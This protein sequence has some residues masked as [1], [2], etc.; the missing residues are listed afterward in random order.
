[1]AK[2]EREAAK[3]LGET[4]LNP[5]RRIIQKDQERYHGLAPTPGGTG[6]SGGQ[7]LLKRVKAGQDVLR[8]QEKAV[9]DLLDE[10]AKR[11]SGKPFGGQT[12]SVRRG[13]KVPFYEDAHRTLVKQHF[14]D[15]AKQQGFDGFTQ[16]NRHQV[17][18]NAVHRELGKTAAEAFRRE[19]HLVKE[20]GLPRAVKRGG[21]GLYGDLLRQARK[22]GWRSGN[23]RAMRKSWGDSIDPELQEHLWNLEDG[24]DLHAEAGAYLKR[25]AKEV[26]QGKRGKV[27][28]FQGSGR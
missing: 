20:A 14:D 23:L 21:G 2:A 26:L 25:Q 15:L 24:A 13:E 19:L 1:L 28:K 4:Y 17:F 9:N 18:E 16:S 8:T 5:L 10:A 6:T 3:D 11:R 22:E 7:A 27:L 12:W